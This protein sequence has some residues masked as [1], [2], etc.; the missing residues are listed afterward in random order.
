M[1][2]DIDTIWAKTDMQ[3]PSP[4]RWLPLTRHLEDTR[5]VAKLIWRRWLSPHVKAILADDL[6]TEAAAYATYQFLAATH[7]IG[8]ASPAFAVQLLLNDHRIME[9]YEYLIQRME[10]SGYKIPS[11]AR[12]PMRGKFR[13]ELVGYYAMRKW[14]HDHQCDDITAESYADV[15]AA[16]HGSGIDFNAIRRT[17]GQGR[18]AGKTPPNKAYVGTGAWGDARNTLIDMQWT[19][20][21]MTMPEGP[22]TRRAQLLL[23]AMVIMADWI[24]SDQTR[25]P[26]IGNYETSSEQRAAQ[27]WDE[28]KLPEPWHPQTTQD[29][30]SLFEERFGFAPR[31]FQQEAIHIARTM[32]EPGIMV[33]EAPMGEGKTEAALAAA[34]ILASRFGLGG[35]YFAL[36]TQA[37]ANAMFDRL[38]AWLNRMPANGRPV[39]ESVFLAHGRNQFNDSFNALPAWFDG[40][41]GIDEQEGDG[42]LHAV[43]NSWLRG[44]KRGN[45]ANFV[46]GTIDQVLAVSLRSRHLVLRHLS[47]ANKVVVLDEV[48]ACDAYMSQYLDRTLEWLGRMRVPVILLSAT[49]T[50]DKR[51]ELID[52]Y[53]NGISPDPRPRDDGNRRETIATP[54]ISTIGGSSAPDG[55]GRKSTMKVRLLHGGE[56]DRIVDDAWNAGAKIAIIRNTVGRALSTYDELRKHGYQPVLDHSRFTAKDRAAHDDNVLSVLGP[57]AHGPAIVVATQVME[58]SLDVDADIMISDMAPMDLLLQRAGRLHRH[59]QPRPEGYEQPTLLLDGVMVDG[60]S[61]R[62]DGSL[63]VGYVYREWQLMRALAVMGFHDSATATVRF[64]ADIPRLVAEAYDGNAPTVWNGEDKALE[65][66]Q[67]AIAAKVEKTRRGGMLS[68]PW[69]SR[70]EGPLM[71][72]W[73]AVGKDDPSNDENRSVRDGRDSI[74][75]ILMERDG[76]GNLHAFGDDKPLPLDPFDMDRAE[77]NSVLSRTVSVSATML[78]GM[79]LDAFRDAIRNVERD[80]FVDGLGKHGP[81]QGR[82]I[83]VLGGGSAVVDAGDRALRVEYDSNRGLRFSKSA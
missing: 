32:R 18:F 38:L 79:P 31:P 34:E 22:L 60:E 45:L 54:L 26:L 20:T 47:M 57:S 42:Y 30:S 39:A 76:D 66:W 73:L 11:A 25:F 71:V 35:V 28:L 49:L 81:L 36:P 40:G 52:E 8:K 46:V 59:E 43:A 65:N 2:A 14:L 68:G 50:P 29:E 72:N 48:H 82:P 17:W 33:L 10:D 56:L 27:A 12:G 78:S 75:V 77:V 41:I 37:T 7:D 15:L 16:H 6:G 9:N 3:H 23:T 70:E 83:L 53:E 21:G 63:K 19:D 24:A 55:S 5:E 67:E 62:F 4:E 74:D 58:Q 13:H 44:G 51:R 61:V 69:Q 64:P 80:W 1:L